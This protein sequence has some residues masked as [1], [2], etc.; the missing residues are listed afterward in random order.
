MTKPL[1]LFEHE[2]KNFEWSERDWTLID[3]INSALGTDV[4]RLGMKHGEKRIRA[5]QHVGVIR[6]KGR[7]IQ[8]LPKI[9]QARETDDE[10]LKAKEATANLLRMLNYAGELQVR[11]HELAS[12]LRQTDDWFEILTRLFA[13]HLREEWQGGAHRTYEVVEDELPVLKGKWRIADQLRKP[14]RRATFSVTYDEFTSDNKLNRIFRHVVERL[15]FLTRDHDNHQLLNE[16]RQWMDEVTLV[17]R[18]TPKDAD[19]S[20][21]TRLT[22]RYRPLLNLAR[23]FLDGG[24]LQMT[25][26]DLS[27]FAFVFD[28]NLLFENFLASFIRRHAAHILPESFLRY[29][30]LPQSHGARRYLARREDRNVFQT[31]PDIAFRDGDAFNLLIDTKYKLLDDKERNLGVSQSDFYQMHAYA[32]RYN[33]DRVIL[34]YPSKSAYGEHVNACFKLEDCQKVIEATSVNISVDLS[35]T[36]GRAR[37]IAQLKQIFPQE[38][39]S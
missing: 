7:T 35:S 12:L 10:Q 21:L 13:T 17:P 31:I 26:G 19:P 6:L 29:E 16:L 18:V 15:S 36:E 25:S 28:M 37:L 22:E 23:I 38:T 8:V 27:T 4:L 34:L 5:S 14:E 39:S 20:Q 30:F 11:E 2:S 1:T 3:R 24:A 33:C 32:H 9:Y